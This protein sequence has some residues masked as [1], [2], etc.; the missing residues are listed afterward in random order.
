MPNPNEAHSPALNATITALTSNAPGITNGVTLILPNCTVLN[1]ML[2]LRSSSN[3]VKSYEG[4]RNVALFMG[5]AIFPATT[6]RWPLQKMAHYRILI[7]NLLVAIAKDKIKLQKN[8]VI[9]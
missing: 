1:C 4:P 9:L 2:R 7:I 6:P 8:A 5:G 3:K